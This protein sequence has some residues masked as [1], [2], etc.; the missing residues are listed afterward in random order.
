MKFSC[1]LV[2]LSVVSGYSFAQKNMTGDA[3]QTPSGNIHCAWEGNGVRCDMMS[4]QGPTPPKPKS[5]PVDFG[6]AFGLPMKGSASWL[7]AG[8]TVA[9]AH[10]TLPYGAKWSR[11]GI[12]C[13]SEKTGLTCKN[14]TNQGFSLSKAVQKFF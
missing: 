14:Q 1:L 5:C 2:I 12:E 13:E 8:D 3:F 6:H 4:R 11:G 10:P 7:C 9:G